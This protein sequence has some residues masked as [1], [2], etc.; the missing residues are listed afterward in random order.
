MTGTGHY[1]DGRVSTGARV[2]AL[3]NVLEDLPQASSQQ[4]EQVFGF[5]ALGDDSFFGLSNDFPRFPLLKMFFGRVG[6][7]SLKK[8]ELESISERGTFNDCWSKSEEE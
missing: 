2:D 3:C 1:Y 4:E 5:D 7:A 8:K 6:S